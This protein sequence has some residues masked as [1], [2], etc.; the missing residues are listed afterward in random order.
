MAPVRH[1]FTLLWVHWASWMCISTSPSAAGSCPPFKQ[2]FLP[3]LF[4]L[5]LGLLWV[6]CGTH[7]DSSTGFL[8]KEFFFIPFPFCFS[9][10][11]ISMFL[12]SSLLIYS[13]AHSNLLL[14]PSSEFLISV[15]ILISSRTCWVLF[16]NSYL[17]RFRFCSHSAF[18]IS[19]HSLPWFALAHWALKTVE[20]TSLISSSHVWASSGWLLWCSFVICMGHSFQFL[21]MFY[22]FSLRT[23]HC[24]NYTWGTGNLISHS[25]RTVYFYLLWAEANCFVIFPNW[26]LHIYLTLFTPC[27]V[28]SLKLLLQYCW[29]QLVTQHRFPK[30]L[31]PKARG[32]EQYRFLNSSGR[33]CWPKPLQLKTDET[34]ANISA[35]TSESARLT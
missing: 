12:S 26:P 2:L 35:H 29:S 1:R 33:C 20:L 28:W 17:L 21:F 25:S 23:G 34:Q 3:S 19:S 8:W 16:Y 30:C 22:S 6:T 7:G 5:L 4:F 32:W 14:N 24:A 9:V 11:I 27:C 15:I 10:W 18:L 13:S 31:V